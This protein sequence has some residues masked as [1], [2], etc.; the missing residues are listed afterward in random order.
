VSQGKN[1]IF[2]V[3]PYP[4]QALPWQTQDEKLNVDFEQKVWNVSTNKKKKEKQQK[5]HLLS[6]F[7]PI[8]TPAGLQSNCQ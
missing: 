8:R 7:L 4:E 2:T 1:G 6:Y 3:T 5:P